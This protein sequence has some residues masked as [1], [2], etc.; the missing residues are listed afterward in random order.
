MKHIMAVHQ[1]HPLEIGIP[2]NAIGRQLVQQ[3]QFNAT[4]TVRAWL[5]LQNGSNCKRAVG[6]GHE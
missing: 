4:N 1:A 2:P 6:D 5:E 3:V